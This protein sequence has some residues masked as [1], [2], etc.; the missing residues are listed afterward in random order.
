MGSLS[1][2]TWTMTSLRLMKVRWLENKEI[3]FLSCCQTWL[4]AMV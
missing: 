3:R 4:L 1:A 2:R